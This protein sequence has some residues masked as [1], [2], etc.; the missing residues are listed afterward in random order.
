MST[1]NCTLNGSMEHYHFSA[2]CFCFC[3]RHKCSFLTSYIRGVC[4]CVCVIFFFFFLTLSLLFLAVFH[5]HKMHTILWIKH[6]QLQKFWR[7]DLFSLSLSPFEIS[8]EMK[9][10]WKWTHSFDDLTRNGTN[11]SVGLYTHTHI[12]WWCPI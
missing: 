8:M 10:T 3:T 11:K 6:F 1:H 12:H 9:F 7:A 2:G 5:S 4:M